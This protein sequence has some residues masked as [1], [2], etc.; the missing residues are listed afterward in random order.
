MYTGVILYSVHRGSI[1]LGLVLYTGVIL[2]S[3]HRCSI[4]LRLVHW[5]NT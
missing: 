5:G 1:V 3:G 2:Y 4:V